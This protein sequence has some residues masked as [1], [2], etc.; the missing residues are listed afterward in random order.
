MLL[1]AYPLDMIA[2]DC[3]TVTFEPYNTAYN[4][5][6]FTV[7]DIVNILE[8]NERRFRIDYFEE[9]GCIDSDHIYWE[10]M[11][12]PASQKTGKGAKVMVHWGS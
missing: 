5:K 7:R 8:M 12:W 6:W 2:F 1:S 3:N 9:S 11:M 10:G 4:G